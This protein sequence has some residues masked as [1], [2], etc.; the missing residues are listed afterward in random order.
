MKKI[1]IFGCIVILILG[2]VGCGVDDKKSIELGEYDIDYNDAES[3]ETAL[4]DDVKVKGKIVRFDVVEYKP[5]SAFGINCWSGEHLN[6]I[7]ETELEV[8]KGDIVIGL[9]TKEPTKT[10]GSWKIPY[11]VIE[12]NPES[13]KEETKEEQTEST[14]DN[15]TQ[16]TEN[17][18]K[19]E[20]E[21]ESENKPEMTTETETTEQT[22]EVKESEV[23]EKPTSEYEKS[24]V[25]N[26]SDYKLY[27]MFDEDTQKVVYFGTD[28]SYVMKGSYTGSF[29]SGV[30]ISWDD[31]WDEN[32]KHTGGSNATLVDGNG[33]SWSYEVCD[34]DKAQS[35]LD[36]LQ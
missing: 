1:L 32:F 23:E 7:S 27:I 28:D 21:K 6:F 31:G 16:K 22:K 4:N 20:S 11:E 9:I 19:I 5:D 30:T 29:N 35:I 25:R 13:E 26:L 17:T 14:E 15:K 24:Y 8:Q 33:F 18:T 36:G 2:L 3:F 10:L 34:L 12:I